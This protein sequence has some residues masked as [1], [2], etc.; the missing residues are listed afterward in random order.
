L[1]S[2]LAVVAGTLLTLFTLALDLKLPGLFLSGDR[3]IGA[4]WLLWLVA[5]I[6]L[7]LN[8][9]FRDGSGV[10]PYPRLI[11]TALRFI[12]PILR[13]RLVKGDFSAVVPKWKLLSVGNHWFSVDP[14]N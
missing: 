5:V 12:W 9:A 14:R 6:V 13:D 2:E 7:L 4:T 8:A 10:R 11:A 1:L 3:A